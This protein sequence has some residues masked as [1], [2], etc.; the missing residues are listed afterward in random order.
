MLFWSNKI[1]TQ[2]KAYLKRVNRRSCNIV[3]RVKFPVIKT[4]L[5]CWLYIYFFYFKIRNFSFMWNPALLTISLSYLYKIIIINIITHSFSPLHWY[6]TFGILYLLMVRKSSRFV[7][8]IKIS[9][10][11][12]LMVIIVL[13]IPEDL[14]LYY[15]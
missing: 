6:Q 11:L 15:L 1:G 4:F 13:L 9:R 12:W 3:T 10:I 2:M 14:W 8:F 5:C 7:V